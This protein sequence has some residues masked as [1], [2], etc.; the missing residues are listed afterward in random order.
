MANLNL[1]RLF[2]QNTVILNQIQ[3]ITQKKVNKLK[4]HLVTNVVGVNF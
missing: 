2:Y 4:T 3:I 1:W